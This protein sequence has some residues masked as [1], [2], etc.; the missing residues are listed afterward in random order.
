MNFLL[1][2]FLSE[3]GLSVI[4]AAN[5]VFHQSALVIVFGCS[6]K[7]MNVVSSHD[8]TTK[9]NTVDA[10]SEEDASKANLYLSCVLGLH[11]KRFH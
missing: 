4:G 1:N 2:N 10:L 6:G 8:G 11:G 3:A 9:I 5:L 7:S